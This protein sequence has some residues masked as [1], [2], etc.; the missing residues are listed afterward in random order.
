[1]DYT[2]QILPGQGT[3]INPTIE[4]MD[5]CPHPDP[6]AGS[7]DKIFTD[8]TAV[9]TT[10]PEGIFPNYTYT[11]ITPNKHYMNILGSVHI[12]EVLVQTLKSR[13]CELNVD[14]VELPKEFLPTALLEEIPC[15]K[16]KSLL[17]T[18]SKASSTLKKFP[19]M[20]VPID[21]DTIPIQGSRRVVKDF[22]KRVSKK[23]DRYLSDAAEGMFENFNSL[24]VSPKTS[25]FLT[26][27]KI[28]YTSK[29]P[30]STLSS[31]N[32]RPVSLDGLK[33]EGGLVEI[34]DRFFKLSDDIDYTDYESF[35]YT[36]KGM[37]DKAEV[38]VKSVN[39]SISDTFAGLIKNMFASLGEDC[40]TVSG[41]IAFRA[42]LSILGGSLLF[43][44]L[45]NPSPI[46]TTLGI[47][48]FAFVAYTCE[49]EVQ[50]FVRSRLALLN[51]YISRGPSTLEFV[52]ETIVCILY[53]TFTSFLACT[54]GLRNISKFTSFVGT[55]P[56]F[57]DGAIFLFEKF[58]VVI[59]KI[60]D[61]LKFD[62]PDGSLLL[63]F[64]RS[65][66]SVRQW[67][68][69]VQKFLKKSLHARVVSYP[70]VMLFQ[71]LYE[72]GDLLLS[73]ATVKPAG[74]TLIKYMMHRL[75]EVKPVF[76]NF[77]RFREGIRQEPVSYLLHG[78]PAVLKTINMNSIARSVAIR[79]CKDEEESKELLDNIDSEIYNRPI[80]D[81]FWSGY[82]GQKVCLFDEMDADRMAAQEPFNNI[83]STI[84]S[85]YNINPFSLNMADLESKGSVRFTSEVIGLTSNISY[86]PHDAPVREKDAVKR[87]MDFM[88]KVLPAPE[89]ATEGK[90]DFSKFDEL[91][92]NLVL[93]HVCSWK[94]NN[95]VPTGLVLT[96]AEVV[97]AIV[98]RV[99]LK[100]RY[101]S[102]LISYFRKRMISEMTRMFGAS[103]IPVVPD[104]FAFESLDDLIDAKDLSNPRLFREEAISIF[105]KN[106]NV[107]DLA[108]LACY[109]ANG[110]NLPESINKKKL[111]S[112]REA[113]VCLRGDVYA[114]ARKNILEELESDNITVIE[115]HH[116][117]KKAETV[118]DASDFEETPIYKAC[119]YA[120]TSIDQQPLHKGG[121]L[122]EVD[123][124]VFNE[125]G[126]NLLEWENREIEEYDSH[127]I[128][129]VF[130]LSSLPGYYSNNHP[131]RYN[132]PVDVQFL[133]VSRLLPASNFCLVDGIFVTH[134]ESVFQDPFNPDLVSGLVY[135][136]AGEFQFLHRV[137]DEYLRS[138][139]MYE[140]MYGD[141]VTRLSM[142]SG[143]KC[144]S[145]SQLLWCLNYVAIITPEYI[146]SQ[147]L[148]EFVNPE[149]L[150]G[151]D[152]DEQYVDMVLL[153]EDESNFIDLDL[154]TELNED[155]YISRGP[156]L[157]VLT[158]YR[159]DVDLISPWRTIDDE[160]ENE[161]YVS[162]GPIGDIFESMRVGVNSIFGLD[163]PRFPSR[164]ECS[165]FSDQSYADYLASCKAQ[166]R[167]LGRNE[168]EAWD[169][170]QDIQG[171][172][173]PR[174][175]EQYEL[176]VLN[177]IADINKRIDKHYRALSLITTAVTLSGMAY[178]MYKL[179]HS[180][181]S[182][183]VPQEV[184]VSLSSTDDLV[185]MST[186]KIAVVPRPVNSMGLR[187][188]AYKAK[189]AEVPEDYYSKPFKVIDQNVDTV[190]HSVYQK[191]MYKMFDPDKV[192][193]GHVLAFKSRVC[194]MPKHYLLQLSKKAKEREWQPDSTMTLVRHFGDYAVEF[195]YSKFSEAIT[196]P[197][198]DLCFFNPGK[199]FRPHKNLISKMYSRENHELIDPKGSC[200]IIVPPLSDKHVLTWYNSKYYLVKDLVKVITPCGQPYQVRA[201]FG[202]AQSFEAGDC[203]SLLFVHDPG[204]R[205][206]KLAGMF[207]AS[208][209]VQIQGL[210]SPLV[211]EFFEEAAAKLE[212][213]PVEFVE[214]YDEY[215]A[216]GYTDTFF[217]VVANVSSDGFSRSEKTSYVKTPV[218]EAWS[219]ATK[220]PANKRPILVDGVEVNPKTKVLLKRHRIVRHIPEK[221]LESATNT[222]YS[223][224]VN[225]SRFAPSLRRVLTLEEAVY[226]IPGVFSALDWSTYNGPD[227]GTLRKK[228][229]F[230]P[231][232][233]N[234]FSGKY[235][236]L[237]KE[238]YDKTM[239]VLRE[240]GKV[241]VSEV[242]LMFKDELL[243]VDKV[244]EGKLR[245]FQAWNLHMYVI[246]RQYFGAF[247][248]WFLDNRITN[249]SALGINPYSQEWPELAA[250][251]CGSDT[252]NILD[253]DV[254]KMDSSP[255]YQYHDSI[256]RN[257]INRWYSAEKIVDDD[258][259]FIRDKLIVVISYIY[260]WYYKF[261][262]EMNY[263]TS[264]GVFLTGLLNTITL[265]ISFMISLSYWMKK[266]MMVEVF[267]HFGFIA[268][269]DDSLIKDKKKVLVPEDIP[270][271]VSS[272]DKCGLDFTSANKGEPITIKN[273]FE[274]TY[275]SRRFR[276]DDDV[277]RIVA[278]LKLDTLLQMP[279]FVSSTVGLRRITCDVVDV[280]LLELSLWEP[281]LWNKYAPLII[282]ASE[283]KL[284]YSPRFLDRSSAITSSCGGIFYH[285]LGPNNSPVAPSTLNTGICGMTSIKKDLGEVPVIILTNMQL[286]THYQEKEPVRIRPLT[287]D[288]SEKTPLAGGL[289]EES[290]SLVVEHWDFVSQGPGDPTDQTMS[291]EGS[292]S[293][294]PAFVDLVDG[295]VQQND[296]VTSRLI[297]VGLD[298]AFKT[299]PTFQ[300]TDFLSRPFEVWKGQLTIGANASN[301]IIVQH[302]Y[303]SQLL[304][305]TLNPM[306][307]K[308]L[309]FLG[310]RG[311]LHVK[312]VAN[313][314][315][316]TQG[317]LMLVA[318]PNG[319]E[320][321]VLDVYRT[322]VLTATTQ[323][324]HVKMNIACDSEMELIVPYISPLPYYNLLQKEGSHCKVKLMI[325]SA[326]ATG[327][328]PAVDNYDVTLY[329][330]YSDIEF[331]TPT[332]PYQ[333][334]GPSGAV[335]G[336][337]STMLGAASAV[338]G[339]LSKIPIP[340]ISSIARNLSWAT[341]VL[342]GVSH[343]FG[344]SNPNDIS[345]PMKTVRL[346]DY[347]NVNSDMPQH[348]L[349]A[350]TMASNEVKLITKSSPRGDEE[351][352]LAYISSIPAYFDSKTLSASQSAND[353]L[354]TY[355]LVPGTFKTVRDIGI[356]PDQRFLYNFVPW[357][358]LADTL[359]KYWKGTIVLKM[360]FA[361]TIY[362]SGRICID[363]YPGAT[364][365]QVNAITAPYNYAQRTVVDL[366]ECDTVEIE[367]PFSPGATYLDRER[368]AGVVRIRILNP[369]RAPETCSQSVS[370]KF[371]SYLKDAE[372]AYAIGNSN[373]PVITE[374][375]VP[376][377]ATGGY[378][379]QGPCDLVTS[380]SQAAPTGDVLTL[381]D[382]AEYCIGERV[383]SVLQLAKMLNSLDL[384][385]VTT[386]VT[387]RPLNFDVT[388][389]DNAG[390]QYSNNFNNP[391]MQYIGLM[392]AYCRGSV[393]VGAAFGGSTDGAA[394]TTV[395]CQDIADVNYVASAAALYPFSPGTRLYPKESGMNLMRL[396]FYSKTY[397]NPL[398]PWLISANASAHVPRLNYK[399]NNTVFTVNSSSPFSLAFSVAD[400]FQFIYF[401]GVP[402]LLVPDS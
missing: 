78:P 75:D 244:K 130:E 232:L 282:A 334:A 293:I 396:P 168:F 361:K 263:G 269:G 274:V 157:S 106:P 381:I 69:S 161:F 197:Q 304:D 388:F 171:H 348:A 37:F 192:F 318:S 32:S 137:H 262:L 298:S 284:G 305:D 12:I 341:G 50:D 102:G 254:A 33:V 398:I 290:Q 355:D 242:H 219:P 226:G 200:T 73:S 188:P 158:E 339:S 372:F 364:I 116:W 370:V 295:N 138:M 59:Q 313:A 46:T 97:D 358:Y 118:F 87:R 199:Q 259:N 191:N 142:H 98:S 58:L 222:Y 270:I 228:D 316:F 354:V 63:R 328:A 105:G 16:W 164:E 205:S 24:N 77:S 90:L 237:F 288:K 38:N 212:C 83:Y 272:M 35:V 213:D 93:Y 234:R 40:V 65:S 281:E 89:Y 390:T 209:T 187:A 220:I 91:S 375:D 265:I 107:V 349:P 162:R 82:R 326:S 310:F 384:N 48:V 176:S 193:C 140:I 39:F 311:T 64:T 67:A 136:A 283:S 177:E 163:Y 125:E 71:Q 8:S 45:S 330:W 280:T 229:I 149:E 258:D 362:H 51:G 131:S 134:V 352:S 401:L 185:A 251:I 11:P 347:G 44:A 264:S 245:E 110:S 74:V 297:P 15:M 127:Q 299:S 243:L 146:G 141:Y 112:Y 342:S 256:N 206:R 17:T 343:S 303:P 292:N 189:G 6:H 109:L 397:L 346:S 233:G 319:N 165:S 122:H 70:E 214:P 178:T 96:H 320:A 34:F 148:S 221:I 151:F 160:S 257:I 55:L 393:N 19:A 175:L 180:F 356:L 373:I 314:N 267:D 385:G 144:R 111:M 376:P 248:T 155:L 225:S 103:S 108:A 169:F 186:D 323:L 391:I 252:E 371:E 273:I 383:M 324:P 315:P 380:P 308:A 238:K 395:R 203:G 156:C 224:I 26:P 47:A 327:A 3:C 7:E 277:S 296:I 57:H 94:A 1:M 223:F 195:P 285:S 353:T 307:A 183:E 21:S 360:F 4:H 230:G 367:F 68:N 145:F 41:K 235:Y 28:L 72:E 31:D 340:G 23:V 294:E 54:G 332:I 275:L 210:F 253:G 2:K 325:Y 333:S 261:I 306:R 344:Y 60:L 25:P 309:G 53:G 400:D 239:S 322:R 321:G 181:K 336:A 286:N 66:N 9:I 52:T 184:D 338:A 62:T 202:V 287:W 394:Y 117:P 27:K 84:I 241:P 312:L 379:A 402:E 215:V 132:S 211:S 289:V 88:F 128:D 317:W 99:E 204:T 357:S 121:E 399:R 382:T 207:F 18:L 80:G 247:S 123:P 152:Y 86:F 300:M 266:C 43:N 113:V 76:E 85:M 335:A 249:G 13:V 279:Y 5:K 198:F 120:K 150:F 22:C 14:N 351:M 278:P 56:R 173:I 359:F 159:H 101:H 133:S 389:I 260:L 30:F 139:I 302:A 147:R 190:A 236:S 79:L 124:V 366:R 61:Y 218:F 246:L 154:N 92:E 378:I 36:A 114:E 216:Q 194:A 392:Y 166:K 29:G 331:E 95:M 208:H 337:T 174:L 170:F 368:T 104:D 350:G 179:Y 201:S 268:H 135:L 271:F 126:I 100:R 172:G 240:P 291:M 49:P 129:G 217:P 10:V 115:S 250:E 365:A 20:D 153:V 196:D 345:T 301:S 81:A 231:Q 387:L 143:N 255:T 329:A 227:Y 42:T 276:F 119:C 167:A 386:A 377:F 363:Y 182:T 369:L 374:P